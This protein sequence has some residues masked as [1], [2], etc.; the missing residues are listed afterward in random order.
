MALKACKL[1]ELDLLKKLAHPNMLQ[2]YGACVCKGRLHPLTEYFED[3]TLAQL[4]NRKGSYLNVLKIGIA[5][6]IA[7]DMKYMHNTDVYQRDL[8]ANNVL[9]RGLPYGMF[10]AVIADLELALWIPPSL[11]TRCPG[12]K[13]PSCPAQWYQHQTEDVLDFGAI[14]C[15]LVTGVSSNAHIKDNI[16]G[17]YDVF[18]RSFPA[19]TP[20]MFIRLIFDCWS[21]YVHNR[22]TVRKCFE[23]F[24]I[25]LNASRSV[26]TD[27]GAT[28]NQ[29]RNSTDHYAVPESA[30]SCNQTLQQ[31]SN[32]N[33]EDETKTNSLGAMSLSAM[34]NTHDKG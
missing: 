4:M 5:L 10:H 20:D 15:H 13:S 18:A 2:L 1:S 3:S 11:K 32:P 17:Y 14:L 29:L 27:G 19:N 25:L 34:M 8:K 23:C 22:P 12:W 28:S 21:K 16:N 9:V 33:Q 31:Y 30:T 24:T 26:R 6:D 7:R